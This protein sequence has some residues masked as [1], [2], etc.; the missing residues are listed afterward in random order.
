[1]SRA[2]EIAESITGIFSLPSLSPEHNELQ[3]PHARTLR[4]FPFPYYCFTLLT[5]SKSRTADTSASGI[6]FV[7]SVKRVKVK[8]VARVSSFKGSKDAF[9]APSKNRSI[10][11][12]RSNEGGHGPIKNRALFLSLSCDT[13]VS[14][15]DDKSRFLFS[16]ALVCAD[17]HCDLDEFEFLYR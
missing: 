2:P 13:T 11:M 4:F 17:D 9:V 14:M 8:H 15:D 1:V 12:S 16:P 10:G 5:V 3:L 7:Q 6:V